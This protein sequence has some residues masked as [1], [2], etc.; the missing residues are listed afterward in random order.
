MRSSRPIVLFLT[1]FLHSFGNVYPSVYFQQEDYDF[2]PVFLLVGYIG[3]VVERW[4]LFMR[5]CHET[6]AKIHDV[7]LLCGGSILGSPTTKIR[8]KLYRIYRY[9][10][11]IHALTFKSVSPTLGPMDLEI[12]FVRTLR[13][14]EV[15]EADELLAMGNKQRD[16]VIGWLT[17]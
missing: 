2:Y 5:N 17:G 12:D 4:R 15:D 6:Q 3:Y 14:L 9:L 8:R 16:A 7:A 11:L 13:L 10:N 1:L